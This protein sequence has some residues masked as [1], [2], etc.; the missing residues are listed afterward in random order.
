MKRK[1]IYSSFYDLLKH[2]NSKFIIISYNSDGYLSEEELYKIFN[3]LKFNY[4]KK[5]IDYT[6]FR[7]CKNIQN[8]DK[9]I[10]EFLFI[11]SKYYL[12]T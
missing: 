9:D 12:I 11:L 10:K 4:K 3:D 1:K 7:G 8:R 6:V 5:E 2:T